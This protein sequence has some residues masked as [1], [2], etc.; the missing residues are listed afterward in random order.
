[1]EIGA[2]AQLGVQLNSRKRLAKDPTGDNALQGQVVSMTIAAKCPS[3]ESL[4]MEC[5]FVAKE[6]VQLH[7]EQDLVTR[8]TIKQ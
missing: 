4:G 6:L 1:M 5:T 8:I 2:Q 7:P 3:V